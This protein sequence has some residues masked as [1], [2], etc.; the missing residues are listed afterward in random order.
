MEMV[1]FLIQ[2]YNFYTNKIL[3]ESF[4]IWIVKGSVLSSLKGEQGDIFCYNS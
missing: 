2:K 1:N 4:W 3:Y